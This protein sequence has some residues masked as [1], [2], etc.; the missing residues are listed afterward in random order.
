M[1]HLSLDE[2]ID[3]L[4]STDTNNLLLRMHIIYPQ[5]MYVLIRNPNASRVHLYSDSIQIDFKTP[6]Q[7]VQPGSPMFET[8]FFDLPRTKLSI[9][10]IEETDVEDLP[11]CVLE[12][13]I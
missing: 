1:K 3:L 2:F 10:L 5:P 9:E 8:E 6:V 4:K 11:E 13:L 12:M 7:A